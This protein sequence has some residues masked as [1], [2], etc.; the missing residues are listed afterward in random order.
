MASYILAHASIRTAAT[1]RRPSWPRGSC[2]QPPGGALP[3]TR[4]ISRTVAY[5][6]ITG[7][8]V[9]VYAGLVLLTTQLFQ[10]HTPVAVAASTLAAAALFNPVRRGVQQ[11]VDRRFNRAR[12]DADQTVA[13]FAARLK[14]AV[15]LDS[16]LV[17]PGAGVVSGLTGGVGFSARAD[18][19]Q[20]S[21]E[22]AEP[23]QPQV[24]PGVAGRS[25]RETASRAEKAAG[26]VNGRRP[27]SHG[28]Q[29]R[30]SA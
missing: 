10:V 8:L 30:S 14:D 18:G 17:P 22:G 9:G 26:S 20:V 1:H 11:I 13:A 29:R 23:G 4:I 3:G 24:F 16:A 2:R 6:I 15:D 19:A 21:V 28:A 12:Y 27:L 25:P 5:A 7:L